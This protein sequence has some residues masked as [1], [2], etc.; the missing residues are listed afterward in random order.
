M[1]NNSKTKIISSYGKALFD[2]A[3]ENKE[4][5]KVFADANTISTSISIE[6]VRT[7]ANPMIKVDIKQDIASEIYKKL[8]LCETS[9]N[10]IN[11]I[12][13]NARFEQVLDVF[14]E[15]VKLYYKN[16]DIT[17]VN[18]TT[19]KDLSE[20]QDKALAQNLEKVIGKKITI[21]YNLRPEI[22]GGLMIDFNSLQIDDSIKGKLVQLESI[23]KGV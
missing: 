13:E 10:T 11:L 6:D 22:L 9:K 7:I 3:T 23:M 20:K 12:I 14:G 21:N 5:E 18:I 16:K 19:A 4:T 15:F 1:K 8:N 17:V 2:A